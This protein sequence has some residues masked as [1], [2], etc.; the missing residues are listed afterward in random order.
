MWRRT[1]KADEGSD[2]F[3]G[4]QGNLLNL[5]S[6][7]YSGLVNSKVG[8]VGVCPAEAMQGMCMFVEVQ[9]IDKRLSAIVLLLTSSGLD[10][11]H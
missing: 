3:L 6:Y 10:G 8:V 5:H 1:G 2:V 7:K 11:L 9:N 4:P